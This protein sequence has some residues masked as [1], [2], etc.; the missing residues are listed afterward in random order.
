MSDKLVYLTFTEFSRKEVSMNKKTEEI[1]T[2]YEKN[3]NK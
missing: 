1:K 2:T 3:K